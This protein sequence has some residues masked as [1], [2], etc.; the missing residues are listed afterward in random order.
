MTIDVA[1]GTAERSSRLGAFDAALAGAGIHN[2]NLVTYSS[3]VPP[4]TAVREVD[5]HA[6]P[7]AVGEQV[8]VVLTRQV[9]READRVVAGLGWALAEEGGVFVEGSATA[10]EDCRREVETALS[11][12]RELRDW[13]WGDERFRFV[14]READE[15]GAAV[16]AAVYG[17]IADPG[18]PER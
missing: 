18:T 8:G 17:P 6:G 3:V 9:S 4:G 14:Q 15:V 10:V 11:E 5:T 16:V 2:Y 13:D 1:W 12:A 7:W